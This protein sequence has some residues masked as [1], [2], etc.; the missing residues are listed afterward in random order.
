MQQ[1]FVISIICDDKPGV[2]EMLSAVVAENGGN[3]EDSR[4]AHFAGK[5]AGIVRLSATAQD[6]PRLKA[7]LQNLA[8][9]DFK[10][11]IEDA[12]PGTI[13]LMAV[14]TTQLDIPLIGGGAGCRILVDPIFVQ[15]HRVN[16][17]GVFSHTRAVHG[18]TCR[19]RFSEDSR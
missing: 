4:M 19:P 1:H 12:D 11:Q 14:G 18:I 15:T 8:G 6:S 10:L 5:F 16:A 7:A 2:V 13:V 17:A 9:A 3:W